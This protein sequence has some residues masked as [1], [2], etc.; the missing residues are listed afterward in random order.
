LVRVVP[1]AK[2]DGVTVTVPSRRSAAVKKR[3]SFEYMRFQ[4]LMVE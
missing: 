3:I 4:L 1:A 2:R